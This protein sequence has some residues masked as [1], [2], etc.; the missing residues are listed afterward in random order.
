MLVSRE[1]MTYDFEGASFDLERDRGV[2]GWIFSQ[3]L[4]GEVT[5]VQVGHWLERAPDFEAAQFLAR[6]ANEEM[7][8]VKVFLRILSS[9]GQ[10]P[11]P[12]NRVLKFLVTDFAGATF[13]EHC[14][15]EM[16]LGEGF[17]LGAIYALVDTLPE[18]DI[19]TMLKGLA[20]QEEG[21]VSFGEEQT[22][23]ALR[24]D[25]AQAR[26]L[27]GL[28]LV[29]MAGVGKLAG[30]ARAR[31]A[32]HPVLSQ[33]PG[34]LAHTRKVTELRLHRM[35]VARNGTLPA[36]KPADRGMLIAASVARRYGR[37]LNPL[38]QRPRSLTGT[39][40][41]DPSIRERLRSGE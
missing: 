33:L 23:K 6:Q 10:Q 29:S 38:R 22:I 31:F 13:T 19:R 15:V 8:H 7:A 1:E 12:P 24:R 3:F 30:Y 4:Y 39:Y 28:A 14:F 36:M 32:D 35:G 16:A 2:L 27:L 11:Q 18:S 41:R 5:G 26:H 9:L 40:L 17:V 21:H 37:A 20:R 34:F 25:P